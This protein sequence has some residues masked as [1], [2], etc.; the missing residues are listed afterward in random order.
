MRGK[1][2]S[3]MPDPAKLVTRSLSVLRRAGLT[4]REALHMVMTCCE[5]VQA[6]D[7]GRPTF[8]WQWIEQVY[9]DAQRRLGPDE[10]GGK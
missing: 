1:R 4:K 7:D 5:A 8:H 9:R 2:S 6:Q 10:D 3:A